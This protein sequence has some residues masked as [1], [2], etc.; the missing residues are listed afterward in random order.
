MSNR[1]A[2]VDHPI[3][4]VMQER[5]SPRALTSTAIPAK[6]VLTLL[7]AARWTPSASN[8]QPW[9][10]IIDE[11]GSASFE[12]TL[13]YLKPGNLPWARNAA[14]L[15][16]AL[17]NEN[18]PDGTRNPHAEY[19]V[20]QAVAYLT[21]QAASEGLYVHQ[22]AGFLPEK[23]QEH[24][25]LPEGW[26]ALTMFAIGGLGDASSLPEEMAQRETAP[27]VRKPMAEFCFRGAWGKAL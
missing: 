17:V 24:A 27:R 26:R 3:L 7:E 4:P 22:M 21:L 8:I 13:T 12:Q 23:V 11:A 14:L 6:T 15:G 1:K 2:P 9:G 25:G 10:F 16:V 18:R 20:G 19:D 5:W